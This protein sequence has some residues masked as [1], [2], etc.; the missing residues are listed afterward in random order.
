[1]EKINSE[2][3]FLEKESDKKFY[4]ENKNIIN[5]IIVPKPKQKSKKKIEDEILEEEEQ[6]LKELKDMKDKGMTTVA[7]PKMLDEPARQKT[8]WDFLLEEMAWLAKDF[9]EERIWKTEAAK[10]IGKKII[11]YEETKK[12]KILKEEKVNFLI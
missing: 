8:H 10:K 6:L 9:K 12:N 3:N 1:M 2:I 11:T 5:D 4:F 7:I